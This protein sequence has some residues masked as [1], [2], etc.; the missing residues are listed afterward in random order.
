MTREEAYNAMQEGLP[1]S[2]K[3][4]AE[5]EFLYMDQDYI[6]RD[7]NGDVFEESWDVQETSE[8]FKLGWYIY[9][10]KKKIEIKKAIPFKRPAKYRIEERE[11]ISHMPGTKCAGKDICLQYSIGGETACV[12]C[13]C[14]E[15][16]RYINSN[17]FTPSKL[18]E[19]NSEKFTNNDSI[20]EEETIDVPRKRKGL[21]YK[22]RKIFKRDESR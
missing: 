22:I 11:M 19:L 3:D 18:I 13:D 21:F 10:N 2:H 4:F 14:T 12:I 8:R 6:I 20:I 16:Q 17:E 1:I 9:K 7:E 5:D 15:E